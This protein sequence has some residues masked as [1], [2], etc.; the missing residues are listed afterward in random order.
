M[1]VPVHAAVRRHV[2]LHAALDHGRV[3]QGKLE[4]VCYDGLAHA[5]FEQL[6]L[7]RIVVGNAEMAHLAGGF[8]QVEGFRYL[9]RLH[10]RIRAVQNENVQIVR[11]QPL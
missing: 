8:Q 4:L 7:R 10:E 2:D 6:N 9:L 5:F 3:G 11:A 1:P